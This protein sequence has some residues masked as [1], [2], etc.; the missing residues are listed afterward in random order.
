MLSCALTCSC[1]VSLQVQEGVCQNLKLCINH[2][3][4]ALLSFAW[5][6]SNQSSKQN[7]LALT[8]S[9]RVSVQVQ[10]DVYEKLDRELLVYVEDVLLN[11]RDDSTERLM[12][13]AGTIDAKSKPCAVRRLNGAAAP[14]VDMPARVR[15]TSRSPLKFNNLIVT[16]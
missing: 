9:C 1:S 8:R 16:I 3:C 13:F 15:I 14:D 6:H 4:I 2:T 7:S 11:R 12:E 10:E 5:T